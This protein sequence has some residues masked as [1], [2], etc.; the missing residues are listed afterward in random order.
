M[1]KLLRCFVCVMVLFFGGVIT[2]NATTITTSAYGNIYDS[3]Y[4]Y[5]FSITDE[6]FDGE[7]STFKAE[8]LND[9]HDALID[10]L[11]F[12][13]DATLGTNFSITDISPDWT[14]SAS[15]GPIQFDY[16]GDSDT[17]VDK[18]GPSEYLT[19][20]FDFDD[21]YFAGLTDPF[22]LWTGTSGSAGV[23]IGGG[24]D[25]GQVAVSFQGIGGGDA[26]PDDSD[27]LASNWDPGTTPVPEPAT[28]LLLGAGLV[29]L[30]GFGR[31][32]IKK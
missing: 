10:L 2:A 8:L 13:M 25:F 29:G 14:F 15:S 9:S 28:L 4:G 3:E 7:A 32:K 19:F 18:I 5:I 20:V 26:G 31:K 30:A 22:A 16:I 11:A 23:G 6:D 1:K 12:N 21:A 17:T 24:D 27:L